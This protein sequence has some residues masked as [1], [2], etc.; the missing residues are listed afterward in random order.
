MKK[1]IFRLFAYR[2]VMQRHNVDIGPAQRVHD[3]L[4]FPGGH[5]K[6]PVYHS[7]SALP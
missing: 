7:E 1:I 6:I 4:D 3:R 2:M 5:G